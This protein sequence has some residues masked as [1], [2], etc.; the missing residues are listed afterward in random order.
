MNN[1]TI[2][3]F[4]LNQRLPGSAK[5]A[6]MPLLTYWGITVAKAAQTAKDPFADPNFFVSVGDAAARAAKKAADENDRLGLPTPVRGEDGKI[7]YRLRGEIVAKH[8]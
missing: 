7:A 3:V 4:Y 6:K 8:E 1:N 5:I 2:I